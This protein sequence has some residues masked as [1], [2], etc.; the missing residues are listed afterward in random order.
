V[1]APE[2]THDEKVALLRNWKSLL[3]RLRWPDT[4]PAP[5]RTAGDVDIV[6][7]AIDWK[8]AAINA[9]LGELRQQ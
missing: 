6:T 7:L 8:L 9:A 1:V 2:L 5:D 3:E 4:A